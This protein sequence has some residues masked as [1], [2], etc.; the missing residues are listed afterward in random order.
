MTYFAFRKFLRK[1]CAWHEMPKIYN[2]FTVPSLCCLLFIHTLN[3]YFYSLSVNIDRVPGTCQTFD[4]PDDDQTR[5]YWSSENPCFHGSTEMCVL[6]CSN[7][8]CGERRM[9]YKGKVKRRSCKTHNSLL[10]GSK[11]KWCVGSRVY[12]FVHEYY[13][14]SG[15]DERSWRA[16]EINQ[17]RKSQTEWDPLSYFPP[18]FLLSIRIFPL[19]Y[20]R[21]NPESLIL[22]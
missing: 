6:R 17:L 22:A 15:K 13:V 12:G 8:P 3:K 20:N 10:V 9:K 2:P 21:G 4:H 19:S 1:R 18:S 11:E 16:R 7:D 14:W 5:T